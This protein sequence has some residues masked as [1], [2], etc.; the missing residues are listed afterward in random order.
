[1]SYISGLGAIAQR[2]T[3]PLHDLQ[4]LALE[5]RSQ[6]IVRQKEK[7]E[8]EIGMDKQT[9][10]L[11]HAEQEIVRLQC[12]LDVATQVA[13]HACKAVLDMCPEFD[14]SA[15]GLEVGELA[16]NLRIGSLRDN[17]CCSV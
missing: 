14:F 8:R 16:C 17:A 2:S 5:Y 13:P 11:H 6:M 7:H 15:R 12:L 3:N 10:A 9:M 1:M 4:E